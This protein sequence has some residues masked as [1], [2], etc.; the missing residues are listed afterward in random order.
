MKQFLMLALLTASQAYGGNVGVEEARYDA[1]KKS[2]ELDLV[3]GGGCEEHKFKLKFSKQCARSMPGRAT[4]TLVHAK[5]AGDKC[6]GMMRETV[7][8]SIK[9]SPCE[10]EHELDIF[11]EEG[12]ELKTVSIETPESGADERSERIHGVYKGI[13]FE[14]D[15]D[16]KV[17][18]TLTWDDGYPG[19]T[20]SYN[21]N[22]VPRPRCP[23]ETYENGSRRVY[24][25]FLNH[26][27]MFEKRK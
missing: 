26:S 15:L 5:G 9:Q 12:T 24:Y 4:A 8:F 22:P 6:R 1:K 11:S 21:P 27:V 23:C 17:S 10:G 16:R 14:V 18:A 2:V 20:G 3:Y 7:R 19:F 13:G 25:N